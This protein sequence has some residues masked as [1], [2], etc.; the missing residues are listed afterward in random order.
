MAPRLLAS[1]TLV[2]SRG[3][4]GGGLI[5][6]VSVTL[7]GCCVD[8]LSSAR[9]NGGDVCRVGL[10]L[11]PVVGRCLGALLWGALGGCELAVVGRL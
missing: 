7:F 6:A 4:G 10:G 2:A 3:G 5:R 11:A 1:S 8:A 9:P